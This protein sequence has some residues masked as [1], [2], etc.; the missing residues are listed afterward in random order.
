MYCILI[1]Q[2]P[3][4][5]IFWHSISRNSANPSSNPRRKKIPSHEVFWNF[6]KR[7]FIL[8]KSNQLKILVEISTYKKKI[9]LFF[10]VL[11]SFLLI[12]YVLCLFPPHVF[13]YIYFLNSLMFFFS[14]SWFSWFRWWVCFNVT[15]RGRRFSWIVLSLSMNRS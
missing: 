4:N 11:I 2:I 14:V 6:T 7:Q 15:A 1:S 5:P 10:L 3:N 9:S 8:Q 12:F 13:F